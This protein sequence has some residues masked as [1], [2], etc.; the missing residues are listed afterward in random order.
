M[1]PYFLVSYRYRLQMLTKDAV[2]SLPVDLFFMI[3]KLK[4]LKLFKILYIKR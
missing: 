2:L 3:C 4:L 1:G